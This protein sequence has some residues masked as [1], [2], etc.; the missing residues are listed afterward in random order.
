MD[1]ANFHASWL[2]RTLLRRRR[3]FPDILIAS[4]T[5]SSASEPRKSAI[6]TRECRTVANRNRVS[7][8]VTILGARL[9]QSAVCIGFA[10]WPRRPAEVGNAPLHFSGR[11]VAQDLI[12]RLHLPAR[13]RR[14]LRRSLCTVR[15]CVERNDP[16]PRNRLPS[17]FN[18]QGSQR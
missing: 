10:P 13:Q 12:L 11:C 9:W 2:P 18:H 15:S 8:G 7:T 3:K 5:G 16:H 1:T 6:F 17:D 14:H 4:E